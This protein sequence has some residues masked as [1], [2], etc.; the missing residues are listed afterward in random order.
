MAFESIPTP[1]VS[2]ALLIGLAEMGDKSQLVCM[3]LA[4]RHRPMPVVAGA[5]LAFMVLNGVAVTLGGVLAQLLPHTLIA[6]L[7]AGLFALFGV[8]ML[9]T[10]ADDEEEPLPPSNRSLFFT[11]LS[12]IL[13]AEMGDKTQ[14][15]V[16]GLST[17]LNPVDVWLGATLALIA[18][19]AMGALLGHKVLTRMPMQRLHQAGGLLFLLM[20]LMALS[21][22]W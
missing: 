2:T 3:V 16:A 5:A 11:A 19:S 10:P 4:A 6:L 14:I 12:M 1:I 15:A 9:R 22:L 8:Q 13:M 17:T 7:A 20:A 21:R 18:T